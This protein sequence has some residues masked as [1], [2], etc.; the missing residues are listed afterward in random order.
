MFATP[1]LPQQS[2]E[3][4]V[5]RAMKKNYG[6]RSVAF[7]RIVDGKAKE[8]VRG[9][10]SHFGG[11][12]QPLEV[13]TDGDTALRQWQQRRCQTHPMYWTG[14]LENP[15]CQAQQRGTQSASKQGAQILRS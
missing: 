14:T 9:M 2:F 10:L 7:V 8:R 6:Q 15:H 5:G 12:E 3:V 11:P 13:F 1:T 4:V